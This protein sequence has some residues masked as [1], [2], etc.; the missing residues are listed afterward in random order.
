MTDISREEALAHF[1]VK[2]MRWGVTK[3]ASYNINKRKVGGEVARLNKVSKGT[4]GKGDKV[5]TALQS[6]LLLNKKMAGNRSDKLQAHLDRLESGQAKTSDILKMY[7]NAS[8][9]ELGFESRR[10]RKT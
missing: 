1:G 5:V 6:P 8:I 3:G 10:M 7:G 2:G 9:L 4:A